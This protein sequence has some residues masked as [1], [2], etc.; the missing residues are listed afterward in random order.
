ML[1]LSCPFSAVGGPFGGSQVLIA[2]SGVGGLVWSRS[3]SWWVVPW[4]A[5]W[6]VLSSQNLLRWPTTPLQTVRERNMV[7]E[8][9]L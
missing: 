7:V 1:G 4:L 3:G 2:G 5:R 9:L 6:V 8:R